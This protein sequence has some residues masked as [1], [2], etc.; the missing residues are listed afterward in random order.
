MYPLLVV[1]YKRRLG[2]FLMM[3]IGLAMLHSRKRSGD[4]NLLIY[5][6]D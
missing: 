2:Y 6:D 4:Y 5:Q 1:S 3:R